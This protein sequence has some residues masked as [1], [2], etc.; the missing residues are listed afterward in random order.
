MRIPPGAANLKSEIE[1]GRMGRLMSF[2][3]HGK[4][5][6]RGGGEDMMDLGTHLLNLMQYLAGDVEWMFGHV[7]ANG[8]EI[9]PADVHEATESLGPVAGDWIDGYFALESGVA[10]FFDS[11]RD[12]V[13]VN[14]RYGMEIVGDAGLVSL[15]GGSIET[16]MIYPFPLWAPRNATQ[17]W[18]WLELTDVPPHNGHELADVDLIGAIEEDRNPICS[19]RDGVK[20]LEMVMGAYE[21]Q[22]SGRRVAFP[23]GDRSHPLERFMEAEAT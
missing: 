8:Q 18:E 16:L 9:T 5:D 11:R 10:R 21:S 17:R 23:I 12:Q 15:S 4:H 1:K 14:E 19:G 3:S 2:H 6:H 7:T 20:A 13:G 22:I